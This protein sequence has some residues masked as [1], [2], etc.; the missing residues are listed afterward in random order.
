MQHIVGDLPRTSAGS[1]TYPLDMV[2]ALSADHKFLTL[3][4]VNATDSE[5]KFS[6]EVRGVRLTGTAT[7]WQMTSKELEAANHVGQSPQVEVKETAIGEVSSTLSVAPIS[8]N[9]Y[10]FPAVWT[11]E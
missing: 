2:A 3:A 1:P 6:V 9:I 8:V 7:I 5:Q 11:A 4:V 10:R